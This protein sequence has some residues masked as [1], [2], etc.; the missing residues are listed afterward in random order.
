MDI[1]TSSTVQL[2][3]RQLT[4]PLVDSMGS[5]QVGQAADVIAIV[6]SSLSV[7]YSGLTGTPNPTVSLSTGG[8]LNL[9]LS[10]AGVSQLGTLQGYATTGT[11]DAN[12]RALDPITI[13]AS[14]ILNPVVGGSTREDSV[15]L[16][17][18]GGVYADEINLQ[19]GFYTA[20]GDWENATIQRSGSSGTV[21][22]TFVD[23]SVRPAAVGT[24]VDAPYNVTVTS[25]AHPGGR[26]SIYRNGTLQNT[27]DTNPTSFTAT[28]TSAGTDDFVVVYT[29]PGRTDFRTSIDN[30]SVQSAISV[31][32]QIQ[33]VPLVDSE[34]TPMEALSAISIRES[35]PAGSI[36][37]DV[38]GINA[39]HVESFTTLNYALQHTIKGTEAYNNV[40]R[41]DAGAVDSLRSLGNASAPQVDS[42]YFSFESSSP[43]SIGYVVPVPGR[44]ALSTLSTGL[45]FRPNDTVRVSSTWAYSAAAVTNTDTGEFSYDGSAF[46]QLQIHNTDSNSTSQLTGLGNVVIGD[47]V[48]IM[49]PLEM[50]VVARGV[51]V[52]RAVDG[53]NGMIINVS[54]L[55]NPSGITDLVA[56]T[57]Y[58]IT[59]ADSAGEE[60]IVGVR[61]NLPPNFDPGVTEAQL[62][63]FVGAT[64]DVANSLRFV[65]QGRNSVLP[66]QQTYDP[67]TEY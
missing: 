42:N 20:R 60:S 10:Q 65:R 19:P 24:G 61:I 36:L 57:A 13:S 51:V 54:L 31:V 9:R 46:M 30:V 48:T 11:Y 53:T 49:E 35:T 58:N 27:V 3:A 52:Q 44:G 1:P 28:A 67:D 4:T 25:V 63:F 8:T 14:E 23:G 41:L 6:T 43:V 56:G 37:I 50:A 12:F 15:D 18:V 32:T 26:L 16:D 39:G 64:S 59:I 47:F 17:S 29:A 62:R 55:E 33:D 7:I 34:P 40:I 22:I 5:P 21:T 38:D 66:T 45:F 2:D